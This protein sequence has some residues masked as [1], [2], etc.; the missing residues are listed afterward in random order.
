SAAVGGDTHLFEVPS[1]GGEVRQVTTGER[2]LGSISFSADD[3]VM[4]YTATDPD[5]PAEVFVAGGNG[6]NEQRVT[7]FNDDWLSEV[8]LMPA[9]RLT[10]TVADGTEIEGWV[11]RPVGHET[12]RKY[13]MVLKVHGGPHAAYGN[14]FFQNFHVLSNAG[15]FVLYSNPIR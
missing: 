12:G 11:I 4:A 14:T 10:W 1:A 5:S 13:P 9:E 8:T 6:R 2:Q 3:R 15:M 7:T